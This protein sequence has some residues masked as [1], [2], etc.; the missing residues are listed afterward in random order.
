[1]SGIAEHH[2][3]FADLMFLARLASTKTMERVYQ[4]AVYVM[5]SS[6]LLSL[7]YLLLIP[8]L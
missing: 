1:M 5:C 4:P 2:L 8:F 7:N 6:C 3:D